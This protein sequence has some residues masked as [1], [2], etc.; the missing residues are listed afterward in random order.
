MRPLVVVV[1]TP[2]VDRVPCVVQT[3]EPVEVWAVVTELAVEAFDKSVLRRFARLNEVQLHF[4]TLQSEEHC[5]ASQFWTVIQDNAFRQRS[6]LSQLIK[7]AVGQ[8]YLG[9][10]SARDFDFQRYSV[11][12]AMP[13]SRARSTMLR[14]ASCCFR[15]EMIFSSV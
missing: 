13:Y 12:S 7:L 15:I 11:F 5:F 9:Y 2:G 14:P 10:F 1:V 8:P 6:T 4:S 3:G